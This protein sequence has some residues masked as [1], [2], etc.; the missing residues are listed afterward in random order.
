[1]ISTDYFSNT[2]HEREFWMT[3]VCSEHLM[4]LAERFM[5]QVRVG[6]CTLIAIQ[7]RR[8]HRIFQTGSLSSSLLS[9]SIFLGSILII[10][11]D[12][13]HAYGEP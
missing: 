12:Y 8:L 6:L 1:M 2:G 4:K 7:A 10:S 5:P 13:M 11:F 3:D 9:P